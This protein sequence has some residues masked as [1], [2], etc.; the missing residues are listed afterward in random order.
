MRPLTA[1]VVSK[2]KPYRDVGMFT[3]FSTSVVMGGAGW[4]K[5]GRP[6]ASAVS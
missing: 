3:L 5:R 4:T 6:Y 2:M 1:M